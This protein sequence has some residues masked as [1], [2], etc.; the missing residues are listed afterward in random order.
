M[1]L[2]TMILLSQGVGVTIPAQATRK[3]NQPE[4]HPACLFREE[5]KKISPEPKLHAKLAQA[6]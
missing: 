5:R 4:T 3:A 1:M 2:M 6:Q